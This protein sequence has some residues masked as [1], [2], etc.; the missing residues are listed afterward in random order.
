M[1]FGNLGISLVGLTISLNQKRS[2]LRIRVAFSCYKW[3][4]FSLSIF[5]Y[6]SNPWSS[7]HRIKCVNQAL[8]SCSAVVM[9]KTRAQWFSN[10]QSWRKPLHIDLDCHR[11]PA[12][13]PWN[14]HMQ[15]KILGHILEWP[16]PVNLHSC[17]VAKIFTG[18]DL[19]IPAPLLQ[20][21]G[22]PQPYTTLAQPDG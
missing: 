8:L 6:C 13:L 5:A 7:K 22:L 12:R 21:D 3:G 4:I 1:G 9:E 20:W 15:Q 17:L 16:S 18:K 14:P 10:F 11:T 2:S 19:K